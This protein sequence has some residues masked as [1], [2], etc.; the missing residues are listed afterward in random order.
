MS[1]ALPDAVVRR[2]PWNP[3]PCP[4]LPRWLVIFGSEAPPTGLRYDLGIA[5]RALSVTG[6]ILTLTLFLQDPDPFLPGFSVLP[7]YL[8]TCGI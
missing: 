4:P 8:W 5:S 6:H 1:T 3:W 7:R 2:H